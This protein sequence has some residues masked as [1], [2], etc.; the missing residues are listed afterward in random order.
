MFKYTML[1]ITITKYKNL[2]LEICQE[3]NAKIT[4][5]TIKQSLISENLYILY[6]LQYNIWK[7]YSKVIALLFN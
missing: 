1:M 7:W 2:A 5:P 6:I 4:K 3:L